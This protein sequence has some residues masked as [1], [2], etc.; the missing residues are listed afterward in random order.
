M[1]PPHG[2]VRP[3]S[4]LTVVCPLPSS[5]QVCAVPKASIQGVLAGLVASS[6]TWGGSPCRNQGPFGRGPISFPSPIGRG[7]PKPR[8]GRRLTLPLLESDLAGGERRLVVHAGG[9]PQ[10]V[11]FFQQ[12]AGVILVVNSI[13][14][15]VLVEN[16]ARRI[17]G[18]CE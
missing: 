7:W 17:I 10:I 1:R 4:S 6:G 16:F 2:G 12:T 8:A 15:V 14:G 11:A 13:V 3:P 5:M 9:S 18:G